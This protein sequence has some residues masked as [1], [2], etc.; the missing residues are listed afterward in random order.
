MVMD[1]TV[2]V[3]NMTILVQ[4]SNKFQNSQ[5]S[6]LRVSSAL[7][8][9]AFVFNGVA[10]CEN[11]PVVTSETN[12]NQDFQASNVLTES[13]DVWSPPNYWLTKDGW[14]G[15]GAHFTLDLQCVQDIAAIRLINTHNAQNK[16]RSTKK[17]R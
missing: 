1:M 7:I 11:D 3:L 17:F 14:K 12:Y 9:S 10:D 16:D 13:Q 8:C 6:S 15:T 4:T 2:L 5:I